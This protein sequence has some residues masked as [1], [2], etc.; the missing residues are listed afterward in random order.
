MTENIHLLL[1][2]ALLAVLAIKVLA[3]DLFL[4]VRF[5]DLLVWISALGM[6]GILVFSIWLLWG[7]DTPLYGGLVRADGFTLFFKGFFLILGIVTVLASRDYV[8]KHLKNPGEFYSIVIMAILAMSIMASAVEILT[9]YI[10]LELMSFSFYILVSFA[11]NNRKSNEAGLKYILIGA[12]SSA[13]LLYG[14][15]LLYGALGVTHF[16]SIAT[17]ISNAMENSD[18][19]SP[20]LWVGMG[21]I[22]VGLGFKIAAVPFHMWA[23][24]TY[25]GAPL[26]V[27]AFLSVGSKIAAFALVMRLFGQAFAPSIDQWQMIVATMS[28][29]T[30]TIGNVVA[31]AQKNLK[32]LLAYSSIA[33][34]GFMLMGIAALSLIGIEA[35]ILYLVGYALS[36]M[37]VFVG[38]IAFY[39]MTGQENIDDLGGLA[40]RHPFI[41]A[42]IASG[43]ISLGGLPFFAGFT[44]K[45]YLFTAVG[46]QGLLWLAGLA[47]FN[48]LISLYYYLMV[49][50]QMYIEPSPEWAKEPTS[51]VA[52]KG[53]QKT[54]DRIEHKPTL[55]I[56]TVLTVL[57][58]GVVFVGIY[59]SPILDMIKSASQA[60]LT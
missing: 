13:I 44:V 15:S 41:A 10:A 47:I 58:L 5:K 52:T 57:V 38:L 53:I 42:A 29:L 35:L 9:A 8:N 1:P 28:A 23:P 7:I 49:V 3:I 22:L 21:L 17:E 12:F 36:S 48:S 19:F 60:L 27:T 51:D 54:M 18:S 14:I 2:E 45:F 6:T 33:H 20:T 56:T 31:I 30:M 24:D 39:N 40:V 25:E 37:T 16:D 46:T 43:L 11:L 34:V 4:P 26:P 50:R 59:P 55:L 32:R